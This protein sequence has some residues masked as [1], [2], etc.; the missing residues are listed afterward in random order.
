MDRDKALKILGLQADFTD[1]E[2]RK[3]YRKLAIDNH[4]D[5]FSDKPE[6]IRL[7]AE[8]RMKEINSAYAYFTKFNIDNYRTEIINKMKAYYVN[9]TVG[10]MHLITIVRSLVSSSEMFLNCSDEK[11]KIDRAYDNFLKKLKEIYVSYK[12]KFY[13]ENYIYE[14]DVIEVINYNA[15]VEDFYRQLWMIRDKYSR[16]IKFGKLVEEEIAPYKLYVTCTDNLWRLIS[17]VC[18]NNAKTKAEKYK[19]Q[20]CEDAVNSMHQE[21]ANLFKLVD[22]INA[23]FTTIKEELA[24]INDGDLKEEYE[25]LKQRY[26][27]GD[28]LA[29]IEKGLNNLAGKIEAFKKEQIRLAKLKEEEPTMIAIYNQVLGNYHKTLSTFNPVEDYEKIEGANDLFVRV[30]NIFLKY[31]IGAID[32]AKLIMLNELSF[33]DTIKDNELLNTITSDRCSENSGINIYLKRKVCCTYLFDETS[34]FNLRSE[35]GKYY[36]KKIQELYDYKYEITVEELNRHYISLDEVMKGA[37]Y[38]G[39]YAKYLDFY[40]TIVLYEININGEYRYICYKTNG[41]LI[42]ALKSELSN[43]NYNN[44]DK[45]V[46][47]DKE[48]TIELIEDQV[49]EYLNKNDPK[50]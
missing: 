40:N 14:S 23:M 41:E 12:E 29:D 31:K 26:D 25:N 38:Q 33:T 19:Y 20:N 49:Q 32:L 39:Y 21:I 13:E 18:V 10:D 34:F 35:N 22:K 42:I 2:L 37:I 9:T 6:S 24:N 50:R 47:N 36:I 7:A 46:Y 27:I 45:S 3:A 5:K 15:K 28:A 16:E 48:H 30:M 43:T 11:E 4:P 44:V 1:D 8:E 17:I